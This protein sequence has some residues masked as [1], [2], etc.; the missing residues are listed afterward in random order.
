MYKQSTAMLS[1]L[2][3]AA[4]TDPHAP[5]I[6]GDASCSYGGL[7]RL[8][9]QVSG[10][11]RARGVKAG[12]RVFL[13]GTPTVEYC[14]A[15]WG[16]FHASMI[17]CPLNPAF[18]VETLKKV[19]G[20]LQP[21]CLIHDST[22]SEAADL[23]GLP[24]LRFGEIKDAPTEASGQGE[25]LNPELPATVILTSGSS[26]LPKAAVHTLGNHVFA[27]RAS[28]RNLPLI[29]GDIWL[30]ALPFFHVSGLSLLFRCALAGAAIA[31]SRPKASLTDELVRTGATHVSLVPTQLARLLEDPEGREVLQ[32]MKG[33]L[34]G[35]APVERNLVA[36]ALE[37]GIPLVRS[38]GMTETSAQLCA[39][40]PGAP[41]QDLYSSG[42]TLAEGSLRIS[43]SG[44]IEVKG[45]A[46]FAG[47]LENGE[48]RWPGTADGWFPTGDL[49]YLDEAGRLFII[50]RADAMFISGG[51]NVH[52]E[53]IEAALLTLH[54]VDRAVVVDV[55]DAEYGARP[56]AFI[57]WS[58]AAPPRPDAAIRQLGELLPR[59]KM[60]VAFLPWPEGIPEGMK[61]DRAFFRE[62]ARNHLRHGQ[63]QP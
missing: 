28:N 14:A 34:L 63:G 23:L 41:P 38:Y 29:P 24:G 56:V 49:G 19:A 12:D 21:A 27:A 3:Q 1:P 8:A 35:G 32:K 15:L 40:A 31:L 33:I 26:G 46:V 22:T 51:E 30:L 37:A 9:E 45:P 44:E 52:P 18:P 11:L 57:R 25:E 47:Y 59:F 53:E 7:A 17:A 48:I 60:P 55:P 58:C 61:I 4:R 13:L 50:G 39:T 10:R 2:S 36:R 54:G 5:A 62:T 20:L 6:S 43:A 16:C 42:R